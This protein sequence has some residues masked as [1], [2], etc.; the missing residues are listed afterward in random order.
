MS[1]LSNM[2]GSHVLRYDPSCSTSYM[3]AADTSLMVILHWKHTRAAVRGPGDARDVRTGEPSTHTCMPCLSY[4]L[5]QLSVDRHC[6]RKSAKAALSEGE[7][8]KG[9]KLLEHSGNTTPEI[10]HSFPSHALIRI[11]NT[12]RSFTCQAA[13]RDRHRRVCGNRHVFETNRPYEITP[14]HRG[15]AP[16]ERP[17]TGNRPTGLDPPAD[18]AP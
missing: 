12:W 7:K 11:T 13:Q 4:L 3:V 14:Q 17:V 1:K 9:E 16:G 6:S 2:A 18:V 5:D 8:T 15:G 10:A